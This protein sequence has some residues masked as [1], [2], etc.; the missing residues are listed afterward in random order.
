MSVGILPAKAALATVLTQPF[1]PVGG[2]GP[3]TFSVVP[4]GVGGTINGAG[5]YTSPNALGTDIVKVMDSL[6]A[7][8]LATV[9]VGSPL[10]LF[11]DVLQTELGLA[12]GRVYIWDQKIFSPSDQGLW[13]AVAVLNPK[14]FGNSMRISTAGIMSQSVNM[15]TQLSVDIT[16]RDKSAVYRK[17]E[18]ILALKS[19]YSESQQ[20]LN[21][22][23]IFPLSSGFVNLS[24]EDGA[25][26]PY[27]FNIAVNIQYQVTKTKAVPYYDT[28]DPVAA[29]TDS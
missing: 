25:A 29:L 13:I 4:G 20:E 16:S 17:E 3:Y 21:S 14:P 28:F 7:F 19:Y 12:D 11:C 26:I 15:H 24:Q 22:F 23:R 5:L 10:E 8:S 6:G 1:S 2:T 9:M 18:V 27:R